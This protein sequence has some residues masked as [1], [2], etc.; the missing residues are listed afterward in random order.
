MEVGEQATPFEHRSFGD[1]L[2]LCERY[3][4]S[5]LTTGSG[6]N[7]FLHPITLSDNYRR[8]T[9][10]WP[11]KMRTAPTVSITGTAFGTMPSGMTTDAIND[12]FV[13]INGDVSG[14]GEYSYV[15]GLT[16]DAEL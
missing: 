2:S 1:E 6:Y 5:L 14:S 8:A 4:T 7:M 10:R 16:A 12:T 15:T 9:L 13:F 11:T 3:F